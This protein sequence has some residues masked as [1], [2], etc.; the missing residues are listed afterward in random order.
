MAPA[1]TGRDSK[2]R[3]AVIRTDQANKG[4]CSRSIP[5]E[6]RLANVLIKLTAPNKE[7]IPAR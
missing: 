7:E 6:R 1:S 5:K 4:I 3:I 2:R